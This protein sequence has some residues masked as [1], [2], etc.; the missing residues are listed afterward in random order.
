MFVPTFVLVFVLD[1]PSP[2]SRIMHSYDVAAAL[3]WAGF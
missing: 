2:K 1:I 3:A